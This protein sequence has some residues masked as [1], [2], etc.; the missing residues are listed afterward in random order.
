[1]GLFSR[2]SK[3]LPEPPEDDEAPGW[4]AI[5][6]HFAAA[7]PGQ[8]PLHYA[9]LLKW[10]LGGNDPLDGI[11]VYRAANPV[12]HW[13]YVTY[14]YSDLYGTTP[15]TEPGQVSGYG[16]EMTFRLADPSALDPAAKPPLWV[17]NMLQNLARYVFRSGNVIYARHHLDGNGPIAQGANTQLT[18]LAFTDDPVGTPLQTP[19]GLVHFVQGVGITA[20]ELTHVVEWHTDGVLDVIGQR[21]PRG[22]TIMD[23]PGLDSDPALLALVEAGQQRE[24]SSLEATQVETLAIAPS[25]DGLVVTLSALAPPTL[26]RSI[27]SRLPFG[28]TITLYGTNDAVEFLPEPAAGPIR[29]VSQADQPA[30]V[31][32]TPDGVAALAGLPQTPGDHR[33]DAVPGVIWRLVDTNRPA[34]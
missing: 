26:A 15:A 7:Y 10:A 16:I 23:R 28:R 32:L 1:M 33:V 18:A 29:T 12:P 19:A 30:Q 20:A 4:D 13:H 11:S 34:S 22:I 2:K 21:W 17:A 31:S 5:T 6:N 8:E 3:S 14:G 25:P 9:T 24:G 27:A